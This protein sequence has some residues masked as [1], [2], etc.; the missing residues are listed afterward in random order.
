MDSVLEKNRLLEWRTEK[1]LT[2]RDVATLSGLSPATISRVERGQRG[3]GPLTKVRLARALG[4][5]LA[6]IFP[7]PGVEVPA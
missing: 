7:S 3:I 6:E 5:P 1:Q 2:V 4:V